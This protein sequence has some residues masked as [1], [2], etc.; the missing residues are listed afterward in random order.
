MVCQSCHGY[1]VTCVLRW[2]GLMYYRHHLNCTWVR[3][4][5]LATR[6]HLMV[7]KWKQ[8]VNYYDSMFPMKV[9]SSS[10]VSLIR[11]SRW[12]AALVTSINIQTHLVWL[13][14]LLWYHLCVVTVHKTE[15]CRW[16]D[17]ILS[18]HSFLV[19][20]LVVEAKR[21]LKAD[22][23]YIGFNLWKL[24][25]LRYSPKVALWICFECM[26]VI[27]MSLDNG[28]YRHHYKFSQ[29]KQVLKYTK[30]FIL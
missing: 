12:D 9:W 6:W 13:L 11:H 24:P 23:R 25:E 5:W 21:D 20:N 22:K 16:P 15:S 2:G 26:L 1:F 18:Q 29:W 4:V 7:T 30:S 17:I 19:C 10:E 27:W 14:Q 8:S 28:E 3:F